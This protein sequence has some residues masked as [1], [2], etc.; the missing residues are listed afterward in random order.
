MDQRLFHF[1]LPLL[2]PRDEHFDIVRSALRR[3]AAGASRGWSSRHHSAAPAPRG[4]GL[5]RRRVKSRSVSQRRRNRIGLGL[6][7]DQFVGQLVAAELHSTHRFITQRDR[8]LLDA[9]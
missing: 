2:S 8:L 4:V 6:K 5:R 3:Q 1:L 9:V 7:V